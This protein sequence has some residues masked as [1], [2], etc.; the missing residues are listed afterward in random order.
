[1]IYL[2][3]S[4]SA[5]ASCLI[6][7]A[8]DQV[9]TDC[10]KDEKALHKRVNITSNLYLFSLVFFAQSEGSEGWK[11]FDAESRSTQLSTTRSGFFCN[12]KIGVTTS[13]ITGWIYNTYLI[14]FLNFATI[15]LNFSV[16]F[17][18][19]V[20]ISFALKITIWWLNVLDS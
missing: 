3:A 7:V 18:R 9:P 17:I 6:I 10:I 13:S 4:S 1:M 8:D 2:W 19:K 5:T 11:H 15:C 14:V 20:R 16:E 12:A